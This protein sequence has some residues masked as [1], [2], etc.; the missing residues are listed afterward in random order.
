MYKEGLKGLPESVSELQEMIIGMHEKLEGFEQENEF[1][2]EQLRLIRLKMFTRV[3]ERFQEE[4]ENCQ[5]LL[6][7][8]LSDEEEK[9]G[10][11]LFLKICPG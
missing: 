4:M 7:A 9:T 5:R 6:F 10:E 2:R 3:S 8:D 1:L 11:D